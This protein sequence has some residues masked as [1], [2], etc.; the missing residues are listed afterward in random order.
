MRTYFCIAR[1]PRESG[2]AL[3]NYGQ[4]N[5]D[6]PI[7]FVL[8][9]VSVLAFGIVQTDHVLPAAI[10]DEQGLYPS[11]ATEIIVRDAMWTLGK[12]FALNEA[13][14][15]ASVPEAAE[16][17]QWTGLHYAVK[18]DVQAVLDIGRHLGWDEA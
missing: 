3:M 18:I 7:K 6:P 13:I 16:M 8:V 4:M 2:S 17:T 15:E 1:P 9:D 10:Q 14:A 12:T 5:F 11:S